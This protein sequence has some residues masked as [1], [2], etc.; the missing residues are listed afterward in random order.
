MLGFCGRC[1][2]C[3]GAYALFSH[4]M[5]DE[6]YE[7]HRD[8]RDD[9]RV[10]AGNHISSLRKRTSFHIFDPDRLQ[11]ALHVGM[12]CY[13]HIV[14]VEFFEYYEFS[15]VEIVRVQ[16]EVDLSLAGSEVWREQ[17]LAVDLLS[18]YNEWLS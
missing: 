2:I 9:Q 18:V 7:H 12:L 15:S 4:P 6:A 10:G 14:L 11:F 13:E 5:R 17:G 1:D 3:D 16:L 8:G